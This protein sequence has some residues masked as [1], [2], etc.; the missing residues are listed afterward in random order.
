VCPKNA[1]YGLSVRVQPVG[2]NDSW[3]VH[4]TILPLFG[5]LR[6]RMSTDLFAWSTSTRPW[7]C[8]FGRLPTTPLS[9]RQHQQIQDQRQGEPTSATPTSH[10]TPTTTHTGNSRNLSRLL[11]L[12]PPTVQQRRKCGWDSRCRRREVSGCRVAG[13]ACDHPGSGQ[14]SRSFLTGAVPVAC[15]S[16]CIVLAQLSSGTLLTRR[17]N[18]PASASQNVTYMRVAS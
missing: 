16:H 13:M 15:A 8:G 18:G 11:L 1:R 2:E 14:G 7:L 6:L 17:V 10:I 9:R 3:A 12:L 4:E 5:C